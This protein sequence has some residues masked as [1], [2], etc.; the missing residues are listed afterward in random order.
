[1]KVARQATIEREV[2][3]GVWPGFEL[4]D[5]NGTLDGAAASG[6]E[7]WRLEAVYF[8]TPDLR[9]LRRGVTVRFRRGE[10]PAEVW[11]AKLPE[12]TPALGASRHEISIPGKASSMPALLEDLARGWALGA[13]LMPVARLRTVRHRT[14]LRHPNGETLAVV[15][16]DEVSIL[17]RSRVAA[18]FRELELELADGA[19]SK[20]LMRLARRMRSAGA[21]P[22]DRIPKL[23]RA[24][25]PPALA[26]WDLASPKLRPRPAAGELIRAGLVASAAR[27][28]DHLASVV[29]DQDPEGVHQA[30][31]GIRRLRSDLRTVRSLLDGGTVGALRR[32]LDWL[33][34]QLGEV[35]DLDVLLARLHTDV[36]SLDA[37]D[38]RGADAVLA[39]AAED[40][41][42]AY[43]RLRSDLRTPRCAAV[44]E[45]TARLATA[46]PFEARTA[47]RP[48]A[49]ILPHLVRQD[50]REL[51]R[52]A[53][54]HGDAPD[55]AAL[56]RLR[57]GVKRVR[58][59]AELTAPVAG[60][61]ARRAAQ[62]LARAQ[63]V[64]GDHND[65]CTA[66]VALRTLGER[67]NS[68]GAWAAGLLGGLQ[69][70]R[71]AECRT[72]FTAVWAD[73]TKAKL[74]RWV[75]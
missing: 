67:T 27:L 21:Q 50:L 1:L 29:L 44:L 2:K 31:V 40:R 5:L 13:P 7:E 22:I 14:T 35:R 54:R 24:L 17:Q 11:T 18:R 75:E 36:E 49:E 6:P 34:S 71:A 8:D 66:V 52:E 59:A 55:D 9:L 73:A 57:I 51:L 38:R 15:D 60:K 10:E 26:P 32:E 56:H 61:R 47:K 62:G 37:A 25:G 74:W 64:L 4:P 30:R 58:Y 45:D 69:L 3:L 33:G 48:A 16:D 20:L 28:V 68:S 63:D 46:P 39:K 19:P 70:A 43:E 72:R 42:A 41:A 23:V 12:E 53:K 65:A